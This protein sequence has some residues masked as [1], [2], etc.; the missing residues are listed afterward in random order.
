VSDECRI[1]SGTSVDENGDGYPDEC[2]VGDTNCDGAVDFDDINPFV[3][4]LV[5]GGCR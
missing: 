4:C 5:R 2:Q 1:A 3:E